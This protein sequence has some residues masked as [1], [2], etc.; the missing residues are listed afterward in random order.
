MNSLAI[1]SG[2][3]NP[4]GAGLGFTAIVNAGATNGIAVGNEAQV[5]AAGVRR[6]GGR[7]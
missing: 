7:I 5:G 2:V 4:H 3:G 1:G 6:V